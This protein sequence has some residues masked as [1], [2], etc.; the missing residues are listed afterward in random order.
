MLSAASQDFGPLEFVVLPLKLPGDFEGILGGN[1][2]ERHV[3][4][5]DYQRREIRVR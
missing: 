5:L 2:F 3:V 1:F 4:C